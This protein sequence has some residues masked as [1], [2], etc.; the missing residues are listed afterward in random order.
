[1]T[2][3][4]HLAAQKYQDDE[5]KKKE[6]IDK[7]QAALER[8]EATYR[9]MR[10]TIKQSVRRQTLARVDITEEQRDKLEQIELDSK[11]M[12]FEVT[13]SNPGSQSQHISVDQVEINKEI[14]SM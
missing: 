7:V 13:D 8:E 3:M 5:A 12:V 11:Y 1:M 2:N 4:T 9:S 14:Q 6:M 10:Q